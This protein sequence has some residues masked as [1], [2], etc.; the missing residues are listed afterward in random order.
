MPGELAS[1]V[2]GGEAPSS[3]MT[4]CCGGEME[5]GGQVPSLLGGSFLGVSHKSLALGVL[6]LFHS[7]YLYL[8]INDA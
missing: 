5:F 8:G 1:D 7:F 4:L 6:I 2:H 3:A